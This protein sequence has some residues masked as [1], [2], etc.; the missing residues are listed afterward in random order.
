MTT[1]TASALTRFTVLVTLALVPIASPNAGALLADD[2]PVAGDPP[3]AAGEPSRDTDAITIVDGDVVDDDPAA[4]DQTE[5]ASAFLRRLFYG[6]PEERLDA[7]RSIAAS[8]PLID[9]SEEDEAVIPDP[10]GTLI[11][12]LETETDDWIGRTALEEL[13]YKSGPE[14]ERLFRAALDSRSPNLRAM[15]VRFFTDDSDPAALPL[16]EHLWSEDLDRWTRSDLIAALSYNDTT[17]RIEDIAALSTSDDPRLRRAAIDGLGKMTRD[18]VL[19]VLLRLSR[20]RVR[21]ARLAALE[22]LGD[23]SESNETDEALIR[24]TRSEDMQEQ[25]T[26]VRS[27]GGAEAP[28]AT[29]TLLDLARSNG[30]EPVRALAAA[31]LSSPA[32]DPA[33]TASL[34]ELVAAASVSHLDELAQSLLVVLHNRDD[35]AALPALEGLPPVA[36]SIRMQVSDLI[37]YLERDQD[38]VTFVR[39][40]PETNPCDSPEPEDAE[41]LSIV[42]PP[43]RRT[44]RCLDAPD[45]PDPDDSKPR[46][47]ASTAV[48]ESDH[49]TASGEIWLKVS[50]PEGP[51]CW[52]PLHDL[53][54]GAPP[55]SRPDAHDPVVEADVSIVET[56]SRTATLLQA[57]GVLEVFDV[58]GEVAGV[59]LHVDPR[60]ADAVKALGAAARSSSSL[61]RAALELFSKVFGD[62]SPEEDDRDAR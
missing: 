27:L 13:L 57:A 51:D 6:S 23:L 44:V 59:S 62:R 21:A 26:A 35:P 37:S 41:R 19:P 60:D 43:G 5:D 17:T 32:A 2:P 36:T 38:R 1:S 39:A 47:L 4:D 15:A 46:L 58:A 25:C 7:A 30:P 48:E 45:R 61:G 24:G 29:A 18:A 56:R 55:S 52:V 54:T 53:T 16:L 9:R 20:S 10:V 3:V 49:F 50:A 12:F 8:F 31:Q 40:V 22:A 14:A 42:A 33:L 28:E 11:E 34:A